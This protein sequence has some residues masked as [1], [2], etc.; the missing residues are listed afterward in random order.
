MGPQT[1]RE[2]FVR[3]NINNK[4]VEKV[5]ENMMDSH[6]HKTRERARCKGIIQEEEL[7]RL[8]DGAVR[9]M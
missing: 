4:V 5:F 6:A 1:R 2:K 7:G 8:E 3:S 9:Y